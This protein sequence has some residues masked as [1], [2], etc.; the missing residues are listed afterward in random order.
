[1]Q[2][3]Q[4]TEDLYTNLH[5][6]DD[7]H[8]E[9]FDRLN[10]LIFAVSG[11]SADVKSFLDFLE[12]YIV[13]HFGL[14]ESFMDTYSYPDAESHKKQHVLFQERLK[15]FEESLDS[16]ADA[17]SLVKSLEMEIGHWFVNHISAVDRKLTQYLLE[18]GG[19]FLNER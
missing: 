2:K 1:M 7:Q 8:R 15:Q 5:Q 3:F 13:I 16:G 6:I 12:E 14:E 11:S 17:E 18:K 4:L 19:D 9:L 10:N